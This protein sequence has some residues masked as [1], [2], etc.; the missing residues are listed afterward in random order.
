MPGCARYAGDHRHI[1][2]QV[3]GPTTYGQAVI[4]CEASY[5]SG[6][7]RTT[8]RFAPVTEPERIAE[9]RELGW[10]VRG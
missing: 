9:L 3:K 7:D 5:D 8:V 10:Q 6:A 1:V 2:G 4:A